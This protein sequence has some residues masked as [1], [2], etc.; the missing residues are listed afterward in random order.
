MRVRLLNEMDEGTIT[1]WCGD[2]LVHQAEVRGQTQEQWLRGGKL[3]I[4]KSQLRVDVESRTQ[5]IG[6]YQLE[7]HLQEMAPH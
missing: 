7:I 1:V 6:P 4:G 5:K 3:P 2:Q